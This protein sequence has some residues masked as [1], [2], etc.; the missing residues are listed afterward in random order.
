MTGSR[1]WS[2]A[3]VAALAMASVACTA[4]AQGGA[5]GDA[6]TARPAMVLLLP[7][8]STPFA[9]A[10][11]AVR[12][13]VVAAHKMG[14]EAVDLQ[15][16]EVADGPEALATALAS[17]RD[18][19]ARVIVGPLPRGAVTQVIEGGATELPLLALNFPDRD[20]SAP[21][22]ILA[23]ALSLEV[24]AQR[25]VRVALAVSVAARAADARPRI[26]VVAG[27]GAL[28]RR[29]AQ[30]YMA[31][32]RAEGEVPRLYEWTPGSAVVRQLA[33]PSLEAVFLALTARDAA[34]IRALIPRSV[35]VFGT[36]LLNAGDPRTS[37]DAA[38][39]AHDL[40][41]VRFVDMPWLLEPD[42][43]GVLAYPQ[44]AQAMTQEQVRL[45][46]FGIDAYRLAL[47]WMRGERRF[48]VDGVTGR[49]RVDRGASVRVERT[50]LVGV[51]RGGELRRVDVATR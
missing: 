41:G 17:A 38:T 24:E 26:A 19:G 46:A 30:A 4:H 32:L 11:A 35:Q 5:S 39:L 44:P 50:P 37:P 47:G 1:R 18:R 29:I 36:S 40:E 49:L 23:T 21:A 31:A 3:L 6:A 14:G 8:A 25:I 28:E 16:S 51:Y 13:G 43:S 12:E 22:N 45:Y 7:A 9:H 15:V 33:L 27:P 48:E 20:G 42:H 34:Q 2:T 10:A